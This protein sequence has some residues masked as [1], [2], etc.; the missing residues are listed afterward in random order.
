MDSNLNM[1]IIEDMMYS[2]RKEVKDNG[3]YFLLWGWLV[4]IAAMGQVIIHWLGYDNN[5]IAVGSHVNIAMGGITWLILMPLGGILSVIISRRQQR[6]EKVKTWF[7]D[8]MKYLWISFGV[9]L[10][11]IL[12]AMGYLNVNLYPVVI[13]L[14]GLGLFVTGGIL[15]FKP[16]II[17]GIVCWVLAMV[18]LFVTSEYST[19]CLAL[20]VLIGYIIPGYILKKQSGEK[21]RSHVQAA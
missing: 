3:A 11:I 7:D 8:V 1:K 14:Y 17:G 6:E 18:S 9:V 20:S 2:A 19:I 12:F 5:T 4:F 15:K 13:A 16:L 10:F 21:E